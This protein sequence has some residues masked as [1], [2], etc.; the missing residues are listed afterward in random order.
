MV[1]PVDKD[2]I[3]IESPLPYPFALI[4]PNDEKSQIIQKADMYYYVVVTVDRSEEERIVKDFMR[5]LDRKA[6]V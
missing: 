6:F 4:R 1:L 2:L 3:E 5:Y